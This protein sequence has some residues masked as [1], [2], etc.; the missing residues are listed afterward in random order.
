[1]RK[2]ALYTTIIAIASIVL[3]CQ[4]ASVQ[5]VA[6]DS[7]M[8][9]TSSLAPVRSHFAPGSTSIL[10]WDD[11]DRVMVCSVYEKDG[12]DDELPNIDKWATT[13]WE[14]MTAKVDPYNRCLAT[15]RSNKAR[16]DWVGGDD[17]SKTGK[18]AFHAFYPASNFSPEI[19]SIDNAP[20]YGSDALV[21]NPMWIKA[22]VSNNQYDSDFGRYQLC[23]DYASGFYYTRDQI[24]SGTQIAFNNFKPRNAM[25]SFTV[26]TDETPFDVRYIV[27]GVVD[28]TDTYPA[29]HIA[30]D[31]LMSQ[32]GDVR[33]VEYVQG[34][35]PETYSLSDNIWIS[36][37][38]DE[39]LFTI[40]SSANE[41]PI[42]VVIIPSP[43]PLSW[44]ANPEVEGLSDPD[45]TPVTL[46]ITAYNSQDI[47]MV[48]GTITSPNGFRAG[49]KY[50]F[51]LKLTSL[52]NPSAGNAGDYT[53]E[54]W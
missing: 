6:E 39:P 26:S 40:G 15:F 34:Y 28:K 21:N 25:L 7:G 33:N 42:N 2:I 4:K 41:N 54:E 38:Y 18:F 29:Y 11:D 48:A 19:I 30:G 50:N 14:A 13:T 52:M 35:D 12:N 17:D 1:M 43:S 8:I 27:V 31:C 9:F 44:A 37:Y 10:E 23:Y 53:E 32:Y 5:A 36:S 46:K 24:I 47:P 20:L 3:S 49:K 45:N 22:Y 16:K 51:T